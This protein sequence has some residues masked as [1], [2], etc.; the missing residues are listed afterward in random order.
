[1]QHVMHHVGAGDIIC[2]H[3]HAVGTVRA[4]SARNIMAVDQCSGRN[5][6]CIDNLILCRHSDCL[7]RAADLQ[8]EVEN[9]R[10][11]GEHSERP[12]Q[13]IEPGT[14][15]GDPVIAQWQRG[16]REI[17]VRIGLRRL[18]K[19][20]IRGMDGDLRSCDRTM[21]RIMHDTLQL[22]EDGGMGA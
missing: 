12:P 8:L 11:I 5:G 6:I 18:C 20:R 13:N 3:R 16:K 1:M 17:A 4:G 10:A 22:A 7:L 21:L 15:D 14:V 2:D 9:R 19:L